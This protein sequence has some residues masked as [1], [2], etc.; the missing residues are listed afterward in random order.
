MIVEL[1]AIAGQSFV[2]AFSGALMPGPVLAVT[3]AGSRR[4][5]FWFGPM[6]AV[7]HGLVEL[8]VV[9]LLAVGL[10]A[11]LDNRWVIG[12]IG[13]LG[14]AAMVWMAVGMFLRTRHAE[15]EAPE[16]GRVRLGAT[17]SGII[18]TVANPYWYLW[19]ISMGAVLVAGA[20]AAG[21]LGVAVFFI[22]HVAADF[23]CCTAVSLGV[24][25]GR[26]YLEGRVYQGLLIAC[27]AI[28]LVMAVRF[29]LLA[30]GK[31]TGLQIDDL[32]LHW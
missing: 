32:M 9:V 19:W 12:T 29:F 3:L 6:V 23:A 22:G 7:G 31:T 25:K 30:V 17:G 8:P 20:T 24:A 15:S 4:H 26:R 14:S 10:L 11:V 27:G 18:T 16:D 13:Y 1:V 28:L 5:G 21:W 2:V